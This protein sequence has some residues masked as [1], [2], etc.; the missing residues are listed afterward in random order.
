MALG[1]GRGRFIA[2]FLTESMLLALM[3]A[4]LGLLIAQWGI[5]ALRALAP[6][7]TPGAESAAIDARVL[8]F[9][10]LIAIA[11]GAIFG[12]APALGS[13]GLDVNENLKEGGR[14]STSG[15]GRQRLRSAL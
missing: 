12:I 13:A 3:G 11:T 5:A 6:A 7:Y 9:T 10:M 14:S 1:A 8:G 4:G 2:Q 15:R